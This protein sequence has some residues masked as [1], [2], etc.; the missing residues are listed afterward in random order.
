MDCLQLVEQKL[1]L[2]CQGWVSDGEDGREG[3]EK[4]S[5]V[6]CSIF[7]MSPLGWALSQ[8]LNGEMDQ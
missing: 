5:F 8:K 7:T 4:T 3:K 6:C 2:Q 1:G